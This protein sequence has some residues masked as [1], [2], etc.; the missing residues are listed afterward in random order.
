[1]LLS[2]Y[3]AVVNEKLPHTQR[4]PSY[5]K[6]EVHDHAPR[7][8]AEPPAKY[9]AMTSLLGPVI[10]LLR[11][12]DSSGSQPCAVRLVDEIPT[13]SAARGLGAVTQ[14]LIT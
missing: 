2:V 14:T 7:Q 6:S 1:M 12:R 10:V 11:T 9:D 4:V 13:A 5:R 8:L 3:V